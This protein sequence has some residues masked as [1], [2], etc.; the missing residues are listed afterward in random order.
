ME[1]IVKIQKPLTQLEIVVQSAQILG[2]QNRKLEEHD[3]RIL[4]LES[5]AMTSN[6]EFFAV[7]GYAHNLG[8][9]ITGIEA[10][11]Y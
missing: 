2:E 7:S 6:V 5:K 4:L 1:K 8:K 10:K 11:D 3:S 9:K